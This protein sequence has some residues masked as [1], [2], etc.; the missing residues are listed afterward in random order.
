MAPPASIHYVE[1]KARVGRAITRVTTFIKASGEYNND[2]AN[3]GKHAKIKQMLVELKDIRRC[4]NED[5]QIMETSVG[6]GTAPTDV[7]DNSSSDSL[8]SAFETLFYELAAFA[9]IHKFSLSPV[10]EMSNSFASSTSQQP[11]PLGNLSCFQLPKRTFPT[12]SGIITEFQGFE[13]LFKSILSHAEEISNVEKFEILKMSLQGEALSLVTHLPLTALNYDSAWEILK[14]RYGNKRDLARTHFQSLL[15]NHAVKSNDA[16]SI[17]T[18]V[19]SLLNHTA[20]LDNLGFVTKTWSPLLLYIFEQHLDY[21]LRS[22]WELTVGDNHAPTLSEFVNFLRQHLRFAEVFSTTRPSSMPPGSLKPKQERGRSGSFQKIL[23]TTTSQSVNV[24]CPM[25]NESHSIRKCPQ[26]IEKSPNERFQVAKNY[27]LCINCLGTGHSSATCPSKYKCQV[28]K[29]LHHSLLHFGS[30]S[31]SDQPQSTSARVNTIETSNTEPSASTTMTV[32]GLPK[33]VVLLSTVMLD[34]VAPN[35]RKKTFRALLDSGSQAS[36]ITEKAAS[37]LMLRQVHSPVNIT[38]FASSTSTLVRGRTTVTVM[39]CNKKSPSLC[40]DTLIVPH[41]TGLTPQTHLARRPWTHVDN[42]TLADPSYHLPGQIDLLLGADMFPSLMLT[43]QRMGRFGEPM[44]MET[45]FGWVLVGPIQS[46]GS[47]PIKSFCISV[48]ETLDITIKK[49]WELEELQVQHRLTPEESIAEKFYQ[50]TTTRLDSGR[51]MVNLPFKSARP[52]LGDSKTTA[53]QRYKSLEL[54]L[55]RDQDLRHQ[56]VEFMQD[57]VSNNHME[58][59]PLDE[60]DTPY[61]YYIPHHCVLRPESLTTKLRVVFNASATTTTGMS[62]NDHMYTGPKLQPDIQ[63][64]LLRARLWKHLFMADVKQMYRQIVVHPSDRNY[65]RIFWRFSLDSPIEEYR[66]CTVT[67]GTSAAPYQA[68]RTVRELANV[69]GPKYPQ[70]AKVLLHDTFVDDIITGANTEDLALECQQQLVKLCALAK[71]DLRKW[72]S[73]NSN[74][75]Q[76]VPKEARAMCPSLLFNSS[77]HE[78]LNVLG[79]KWDPSVDSFSFHTQPSSKSP[80]KRSVLSDLARTFDPLGLLAPTTFWIKHFMQCL[81]IAGTNWDD[82]IPSDLSSQWARYHSELHLVQNLHIPRRITADDALSVQLHAFADSSQKGYAAAVYLRVESH[83]AVHCHLVTAKSRVAPLKHVTIPRL[84]LC[85]ALLAAQLIRFTVVTFQDRLH[86]DKLTAWTDSTTALAW[87]RSSPHRWATFVANRTSQIQELTSPSIWRHVPTKCNPVDCASRGLYPSELIN[88]PLWWHGP[89][90]LLES[91]DQWPSS[92]DHSLDPLN[93]T[94]DD[95]VRKS[96]GV[97]LTVGSS[98]VTFLDRYSS[99]DKI[100]R[101]Y[102]YCLRFKTVK[103]LKMLKQLDQFPTV[104]SVEEIH[105][106]LSALI[107]SVQQSVYRPEIDLLAKGW[108]CSK[109]VRKLDLFLAK[110]GLLRVGGRLQNADLPYEHKHP[111]LMPSSHRLTDLVIDYHHHR[112]KHP[113]ASALQTYLQRTYW[114]QSARRVIRSR[115]RLCIPCFRTRPLSI[116]PKMAALPKYRVQQIK[117]FAIA[118]VD[119]AGPITLKRARGRNS[120]SLVAYICLF[121][122]TNTKAIHLELSSDLST[123]TFL[124]A[125]TRFTARRGPVKEIH[126]DNGTNFVGA[127]RLLNPVQTLTTS[128]SFQNCVRTHLAKSN[129]QWHFNPPSSPHFGGLWEAGVK[130]TK[131]LIL[132]S[133][134]LHKLTAEELMTLLTQIEATLNS[135]PLCALSNDP[136]DLEALTPSHFLTLEPSTSLPD[137]HLENVPLSKLTRWRLI[138]D[139][140]RHFWARW[141]NEYLST[142][143]V[144]SKWCSDGKSLRVGDL[145]LIREA[146]HPLHWTIGRVRQLHPGADGIAR[147]AT[148]DTATGHLVRPAVKLCPFPSS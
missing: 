92:T 71:F 141:K 112:L 18:L 43:G 115:L 13:D 57:Y 30:S 131:S 68:L 24:A 114:I 118:G 123:E 74:V 84:E 147:V 101:I 25:C 2:R 9:D 72:A 96:A 70:A 95:E 82:P 59:I 35:G 98:V 133:I 136:S 36:F 109:P 10:A 76:A 46:P 22:R 20:A 106:A 140:H 15:T 81:W 61:N 53:L 77:G 86:V 26:F 38:T 55:S 40:V 64:V 51:F 54:R 127:A 33:T 100:S 34:V 107:F 117:P 89:P 63:V 137:P 78:D 143:Q 3:V 7:T 66:L 31:G 80:T 121:V 116:Q 14:S 88:H 75:L 91:P 62:L 32:K 47:G 87:I 19:T 97:C 129:I 37:V 120:S 85:G 139:I 44:A 12:F 104:F 144:R 102:A 60:K 135:R 11:G 28:C 16:L 93:A 113:G 5:I 69:D 105:D 142:L 130:S 138:T 108:P 128:T 65:L 79:L 17:K 48:F 134:G 124:L 119:Y 1:A 103:K 94:P 99:L 125:L 21:E 4:V 67:Y 29:K 23:T 6:Q 146:T 42:L 126:S 132:R 50:D 27:K 52:L 110:D 41:I 8:I 45:I 111:I 56:Y 90:F 49:F 122:C 73:N 145:V 39:P 148:V 83:A 58:L